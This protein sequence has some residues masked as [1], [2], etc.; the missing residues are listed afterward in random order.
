MRKK[1]E[2]G[3]ITSKVY[4]AQSIDDQKV[5]NNSIDLRKQ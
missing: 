1:P 5:K 2:T 4:F 3:E